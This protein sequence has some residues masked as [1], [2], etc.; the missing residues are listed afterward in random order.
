M[1]QT[2]PGALLSEVGFSLCICHHERRLSSREKKENQ[3]TTGEIKKIRHVTF[4]KRKETSVD[5][6]LKRAEAH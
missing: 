3:L 2:S 6:K 4:F 5:G 1:S